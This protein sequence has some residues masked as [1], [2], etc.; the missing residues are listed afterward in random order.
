MPPDVPAGVTRLDRLGPALARTL[1][2]DAWRECSATLVAGGKSNLTFE[3][4]SGA[5]TVILRRPPTGD[6]LPSAHDMG[7]EA[8]VQQALAGTPVPVPP[9]VLIDDGDL[10]GVPCYVMHRVEGH[11]IRDHLPP[12]Y[13]ADPPGKAALTDALVD[14]LVALHEVDPGRVGLG[15][16][17]RP[18]GFLE[19]QVWLWQRQWEHAADREI[20]AMT[21]LS[22]L[23]ARRIPQT[24]RHSVIHGDYRLDNCIMS[25]GDPGRV[26]AVLDWELSTLGDPLTDLALF[27]LCWREPGDRPLRV[28]PSLTEA[29][30]FPARATIVERYAARTG[31][32]LGNLSFYEGLAAFKFAAIVQ[33]IVARSAA[34]SMAGQDFGDLTSVVGDI[35]A[36]GLTR[37]HG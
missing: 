18:D 14:T 1:G 2:D 35:A 28:T 22:T 27:L 30:G 15:D 33:G 26:A 17:G 8:R 25:P 4:T 7:R 19:R 37:L 16:Y 5:G 6:L 23:L 29:D 11:V 10:V 24:Q 21:E 13:A 20:P 31:L 34:G 3:V 32:D 9:I 12:A 36:E